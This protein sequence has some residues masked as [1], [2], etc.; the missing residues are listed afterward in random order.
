MELS[1]SQRTI[2]NW[3]TIWMTSIIALLSRFCRCRRQ[4]TDLWGI[5]HFWPSLHVSHYRILSQS[6]F[7]KLLS[8]GHYR[9]RG[10]RVRTEKLSGHHGLDWGSFFPGGVS[11]NHAQEWFTG[12]HRKPK[13][14]R[15]QS[16]TRRYVAR[17][18]RILSGKRLSSRFFSTQNKWKAP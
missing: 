14:E 8:A 11:L 12:R 5:S 4:K 15:W 9:D 17:M 13:R 3:E 16:T 6:L 7:R 10:C 18:A 2:L 1:S